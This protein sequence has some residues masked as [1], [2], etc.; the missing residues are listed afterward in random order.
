ML[1]NGLLK[2]TDTKDTRKT[3]VA[4]LQEEIEAGGVGHDNELCYYLL[5]KEKK[6]NCLKSFVD[7]LI[8]YVKK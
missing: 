6:Y 2:I 8:E 3:I 4:R 7:G 5:P 1:Q